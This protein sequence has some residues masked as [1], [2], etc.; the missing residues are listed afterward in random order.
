MLSDIELF[1]V[2]KESVGVEL[3]YLHDRLVLTLCALEHF[4]V[5]SVSVAGEMSHVGDV[6]NPVDIVADEAKV[7]LKDILH[8]VA[9]EIAYVCIVVHSR[10]AGVH[11]YFA[12][13]MGHEIFLFV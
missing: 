6:H 5:A 12:L 7:L 11:I 13:N 4:V 3:C 9:P 10:S 8:D 1:A 2:V